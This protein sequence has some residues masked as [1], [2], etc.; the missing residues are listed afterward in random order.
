MANQRVIYKYILA[1]DEASPMLATTEMPEDAQILDI[2]FQMVPHQ[3]SQ[4]EDGTTVID[5]VPTPVVWAIVDPEAPNRSR[6]FWVI[7]TGQPFPHDAAL[8]PHLGTLSTPG[9]VDHV[10]DVAPV[11]IPGFDTSTPQGPLN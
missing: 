8:G 9:Q 6:N 10:F 11:S 3:M 4:A 2:Q 1:A 7:P 5:L